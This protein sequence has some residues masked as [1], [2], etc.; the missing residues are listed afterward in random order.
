MPAMHDSVP[1]APPPCGAHSRFPFPGE[2][3]RQGSLEASVLP[4]MSVVMMGTPGPPGEA[5]GLRT[6]GGGCLKGSE[7]SCPPTNNSRFPGI[8]LAGSYLHVGAG[9]RK[10]FGFFGGVS[11]H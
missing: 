1:G 7:A 3:L 6:G 5:I 4:V 11:N 2:S 10:A 9:R 8:L